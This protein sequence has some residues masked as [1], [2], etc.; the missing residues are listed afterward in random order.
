MRKLT[1]K[2]AESLEEI[3][4]VVGKNSRLIESLRANMDGVSTLSCRSSDE[5]SGIAT[6]IQQVEKGM[7]DLVAV[8]ARLSSEGWSVS[9][10]GLK[11]W[12]IDRT[13]KRM[14]RLNQESKWT[15]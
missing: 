4:T 14:C 2:T 1:A 6:G 11:S 13:C 9:E 3:S 8:V 12:C 5:I 10:M 15:M 7:T